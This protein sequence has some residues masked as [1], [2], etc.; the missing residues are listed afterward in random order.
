MKPESFRLMTSLI[1][2]LVII[3]LIH[4]GFQVYPSLV[5]LVKDLRVQ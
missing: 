5:Y 1:Q 4:N 2:T 3:R